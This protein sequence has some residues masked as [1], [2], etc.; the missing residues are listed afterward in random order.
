ME[1]EIKIIEYEPAYAESLAEFY[2]INN[3]NENDDWGGESTIY[4]ASQ[5][6]AEH[7][8]FSY[9]N[10]YLAVDNK[11]V[12]GYCSFGKYHG[13][14]NTLYIALL[15]VRAD[16]RNKKIG[17]ALVLKCVQR[18]IELGFPR[19]DLYTWGGNTAAVP[20][21]KKCGFLWEDRP[22]TTHLVNFIPSII[23]NPLFA[24]FFKKTDWYN[25]LK[26]LLEIKPDG[27][28][29]NGFEVFGYKWENS[30]GEILNIQYERSGRNI[31]LIE[32]NDYKIELLTDEHELAFGMD[33]KA[34]FSIENKTGKPLDIKIKG[35]DDKNIKSDF[36]FDV[37]V[38]DKQDIIANFYVGE[39]D[40][41]INTR[42]THPCLLADV[43]INGQSIIFGL[44]IC[45]CFPLLVDI[46]RKCNVNK[47]GANIKTYINIESSLCEDIDVSF[48]FPKNSL[49]KFNDSFNIFI[50]KKSKVSIETMSETIGIG[51]E[52]IK[53]NCGNIPAVVFLC[54]RDLTEAFYYEDFNYYCIV[55]GPWQFSYDKIWGDSHI[56]N[57]TN[58]DY[59][60]EEAVYPPKLGKPYNDEFDTIRPTAK[61]YIKGNA[62]IMELEFVSKHFKGMVITYICKLYSTGLLIFNSKLENKGEN[63]CHIFLQDNYSFKLGRRTIFSANGKI[64]QNH[65][66]K[67]PGNLTYGLNAISTKDIDENWIFEDNKSAPR[68][69]CWAKEY[70][71]VIR[72]GNEAI[73]E[74]EC[75]LAPGETYENK[76]IIY[77]MGLF[78]N[79]NDFRNY[80]MDIQNEKT[81]KPKHIIEIEFNSF[82]YDT[83]Q[84]NIIN[85]REE[86]QEGS[87]TVLSETQTNPHEHIIN[88]NTFN[89]TVD[90]TEDI[91]IL[92]IKMDMVGYNKTYKKAL[93]FPKGDIKLEKTENIYTVSNG[94]ITFSSDP[95]YSNGC[96]SLKDKKGQE[97]LFSKHPNHET[98][99]W[100][101]P[102]IGGI[103]ADFDDLNDRFK[104]KEHINAEFINIS[105][106]MGNKW[107]GI[108]TTLDIVND[109]KLKGTICKTYFITMPGIPVLCTFYK[110]FNNTGNFIHLNAWISAYL[111]SDNPKQVMIDVETDIGNFLLRMG[112]L[113]MELHYNGTMQITSTR[114]EKLYAIGCVNNIWGNNKIPVSSVFSEKYMAVPNGE[115][116]ISA[117]SFIIITDKIL[118]KNSLI[119]LERIEFNGL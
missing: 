17:K 28:K 60:I 37:Q 99:S 91:S 94:S 86:V 29:L 42:K 84:L 103:R 5:I 108:C 39:I 48:E 88:Q 49:L 55:N 71:P 46:N 117:P 57:L 30:L 76:P 13:D 70:K 53:L 100:F 14:E 109:K 85:N 12:V 75:K 21:Y 74:A 66:P 96:F 15:A 11:T 78:T 18:T 104:L 7:E 1:S 24:D 3:Q 67:N 65:E 43:N 87:I 9:Y 118:P 27:V 105:D 38:K 56:N 82:V 113:D 92:D 44:G 107:Q 101:N 4:T 90:T 61:S 32:T 72:W 69:F 25:D 19:L 58:S 22:E 68:G 80:A 81:I 62:I 8:M 31:R 83:I 79:Y 52:K 63:P 45:A 59:N 2:N 111:Y 50:P 89:L 106:N 41:P 10:V 33:Y 114:D 40:E 47:I 34:N 6:K 23:I 93:F 35:Q 112:S 110:F 119:D 64:T 51:A 115:S 73:F 98:Y 95:A 36:Y 16:Y 116:Y 26:P 54:V 102:F 20:L 97:W 77:A